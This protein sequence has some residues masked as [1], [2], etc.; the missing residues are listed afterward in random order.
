MRSLL[1]SRFTQWKLWLIQ[2]AGNMPSGALALYWPNGLAATWHRSVC[3]LRG[4]MQGTRR[5]RRDPCKAFLWH[6]PDNVLKS[7]T[8]P[9]FDRYWERLPLPPIKQWPFLI[10]L[11]IIFQCV[12]WQGIG[13]TVYLGMY[14]S[15]SGEFCI[16]YTI[17][18]A[19][20]GLGSAC[21]IYQLVPSL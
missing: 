2:H 7:A 17:A 18:V 10:G 8:S 12:G 19:F 21:C 4:G 3:V 16:C 5:E 11:H 14:R 13:E 1:F 6:I 9:V 20:Q 15:F